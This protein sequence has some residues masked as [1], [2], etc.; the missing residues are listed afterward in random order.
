M[1][2]FV[3]EREAAGD[4]PTDIAPQRV[5][6]L[7]IREALDFLRIIADAI[8]SA[9]IDGRPRGDGNRSSNSSSGNTSVR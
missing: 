5:G 9:G 7:S 3:V 1:H 6:G 4:L 2:P 8:T